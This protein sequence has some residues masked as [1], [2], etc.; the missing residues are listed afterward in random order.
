MV[1]DYQRRDG[2]D[3]LYAAIDLFWARRSIRV[4]V[5]TREVES[6]D[7]ARFA[8]ALASSGD[9]AG[10]LVAPHGTQ[11][12]MAGDRPSKSSAQRT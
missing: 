10:R 7:V 6:R 11:V 8:E 9:V 3:D 2:H 1:S 5:A 4:R 12:E